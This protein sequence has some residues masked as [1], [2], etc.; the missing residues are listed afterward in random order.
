MDGVP[1]ITRDK[2]EKLLARIAKEFGKK[3]ATCKSE[4]MFIP[5]NETTGKSNG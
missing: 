2:A 4:D 1:I 3:G 5:W